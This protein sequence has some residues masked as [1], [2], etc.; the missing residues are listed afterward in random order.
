MSSFKQVLALLTIVVSIAACDVAVTQ[1][2]PIIGRTQYVEVN[3]KIDTVYHTIPAFKLVDQEGDTVTEKTVEGKI[4]VADFFFGTCPS[5]CPTMAQQMLRVHDKFKEVDDF[6]ILSH[7]IDP[8]HDTVAYLKGYA[9]KLGIEN[10]DT[11]HFL[12]GPQEEIYELGEKDYMVTVGQDENAPGGF[13]H[14]GHFWLVDK[15]RRLRGFYDGTIASQVDRLINDIK[16]LQAE[17]E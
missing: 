12:T 10:N 14:S 6:A 13:I 7:T 3:G 15:E 8:D 9:E 16:K 1:K 5:I 4:Y 2:L 11:W 17:Y